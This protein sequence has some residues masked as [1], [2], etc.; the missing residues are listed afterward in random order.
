MIIPFLLFS[1]G[2][3]LLLKGADLTVEGAEGL[4]S[5]IGVPAAFIGL[6]IVAF[7]TS[8]PELVVTSE[9]FRDGDFGIGTGNII[10]SN[11]SNIALI[12]GLCAFL[13]PSSFLM[14]PQRQRFLLHS[15][16]ML[17]A[18]AVFFFVCQRNV[19]DVLSGIILLALFAAIVITIWRSG[20]TTE[21]IAI[22]DPKYSLIFTIGGLAAV[23]V[24]AHIL[25]MG[26]VEIATLFCIPP[27]V[28][29]LSMVALGTSLPEM[30][31]TVV[32]AY[33]NSPGVAI[34]N[35]LGS[36]IF[37]LLFVMGVNA[38]F[39]AIPTPDLVTI[40]PMLLFSVA[41]LPLFLGKK[42]LTRA[43]GALL[44]GGY[45]AYILTLFWKW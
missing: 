9:S 7:G 45:F 40:W 39:I 32:A 29:G 27:V 4:A 21:N 16:L 6:T 10:G 34:G 1:I 28:I 14:K 12:L 35:I 31:T 44:M 2:T 3:V 17:I 5:R 23:V 43:W 33:R 22:H 11:I 8:L 13:V 25:L 42:T 26:A 20:N 24:G 18:T 41:M 30:A 19:L 37:N 36:N 38:L 15:A